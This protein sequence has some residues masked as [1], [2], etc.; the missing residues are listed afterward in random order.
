MK[1]LLS[2]M[3]PATVDGSREMFS[4]SCGEDE[5]MADAVVYGGVAFM[6]NSNRRHANVD[7]LQMG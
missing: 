2:F 5:E 6:S 7:Q 4:R 1:I 3:N